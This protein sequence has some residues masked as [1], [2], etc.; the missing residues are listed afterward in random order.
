MKI[1]RKDNKKSQS[2]NSS[3]GSSSAPMEEIKCFGTST[4]GKRGQI[5]IPAEIRKKLDLKAGQ[6]FMVLL[7]GFGSV[8]LI[9]DDKFEEM[10][11]SF[12]KKITEFRK[13][14][15]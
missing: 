2:I 7:H 10:I 6:K 13:K 12:E 11:S 14:S 15:K 9:P 1:N 5:V 8:M 4:M 3:Q